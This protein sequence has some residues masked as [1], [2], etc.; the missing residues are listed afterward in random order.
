MRYSLGFLRAFRTRSREAPTAV[1]YAKLLGQCGN[2]R[3]GQFGG[4]YEVIC[5]CVVPVNQLPSAAIEVQVVKDVI[6]GRFRG[7]AG[8]FEEELW[9]AST[10]VPRRQG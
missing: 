6:T 2:G 5:E 10:E 4:Q 3:L 9:C 7:Q 1:A 8:Q